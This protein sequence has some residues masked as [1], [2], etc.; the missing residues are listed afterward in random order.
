MIL[1]E[2]QL[3]WR[4]RIRK[5]QGLPVHYVPKF[6]IVKRYGPNNSPPRQSYYPRI[7]DPVWLIADRRKRY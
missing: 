3:A 4:Q 1:E 2:Q 5:E 6:D 7:V